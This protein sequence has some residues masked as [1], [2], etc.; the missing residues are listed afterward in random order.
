MLC[1]ELLEAKGPLLDRRAV[2]A[3]SSLLRWIGENFP[4]SISVEPHP[5]DGLDRMAIPEGGLDLLAEVRDGAQV[6]EALFR[7]MTA[8]TMLQ[9]S[10]DK[11]VLQERLENYWA[12]HDK[13]VRPP[14]F[15]DGKW[16]I[17]DGDDA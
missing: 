16:T 7:L 5:S 8:D 2:V 17:D 9:S 4:E 6:G 13:A 1:R 11:A 14:W 15:V 3:L 10:S 12:K